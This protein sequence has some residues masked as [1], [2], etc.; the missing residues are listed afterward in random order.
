M[1]ASV[2]LHDDFDKVKLADDQAGEGATVTVNE[3]LLA[4]VATVRLWEDAVI[5]SPTETVERKAVP[6]PV[7]VV[8]LLLTVPDC[9]MGFVAPHSVD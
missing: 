8:L 7:M 6:L 5:V 2:L 1:P 3:V 4:T 9:V